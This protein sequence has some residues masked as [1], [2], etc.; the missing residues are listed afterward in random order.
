MAVAALGMLW[1]PEESTGAARNVNAAAEESCLLRW[2]VSLQTASSFSCL[3][4]Y[5][6]AQLTRALFRSGFEQRNRALSLGTSRPLTSLC[7]LT[8]PSTAAASASVARKK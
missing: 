6:S 7:S 2:L 4:R 3:G 5:H 1:R 8:A